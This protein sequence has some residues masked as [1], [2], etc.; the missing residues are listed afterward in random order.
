[1]MPLNDQQRQ[2]I[3]SEV[4]AGRKISAIKL[5]REATGA[6]LA[7]AKHAIEDL[8]M[9]LRRQNP[10]RFISQ[11]KAGCLGLVMTA[12]L[13]IGVAAVSILYLRRS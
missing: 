9:D 1:M 12:A 11:P 13:L 3:E 4:F 5:Y 7:E 6:G 2:Q 8:E 10:E